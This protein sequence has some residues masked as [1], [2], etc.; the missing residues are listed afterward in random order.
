LN[1]IWQPS[2]L[3]ACS[4]LGLNLNA[5]LGF[6]LG[7]GGTGTLTG[8]GQCPFGLSPGINGQLT[9]I[10]HRHLIWPNLGGHFHTH[11]GSLSF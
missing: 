1:G 11:F 9:Y 8:G 4:N 5:P 10:H 6:G 2:I 7:L 3:A